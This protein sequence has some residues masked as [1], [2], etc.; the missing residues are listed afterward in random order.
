[1]SQIEPVQPNVDSPSVPVEPAAADVEADL[2]SRIEGR[3]CSKPGV[4]PGCQEQITPVLVRPGRVRMAF[5][6]FIAGPLLFFHCWFVGVFTALWFRTFDIP[7]GLLSGL[8]RQPACPD[9]GLNLNPCPQCKSL[10]DRSSG[11][12]PDCGYRPSET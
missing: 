10:K 3:P 1:M 11:A 12:C 9:C 4:C 7:E 5:G 2:I 6:A 8:F